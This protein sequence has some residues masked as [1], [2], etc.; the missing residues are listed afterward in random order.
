MLQ[1]QPLNCLTSDNHF[2]CFIAGSFTE[3]GVI[4]NLISLLPLSDN[5]V[6]EYILLCLQSI[7][8]DNPAAQDICKRLNLESFLSQLTSKNIDSETQDQVC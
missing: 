8:K 7:T 5:I 6:K 3:S 4:E 1:A 2:L